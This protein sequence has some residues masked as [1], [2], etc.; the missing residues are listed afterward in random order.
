MRYVTV[1]SLVLLATVALGR[2]PG[3]GQSYLDHPAFPSDGQHVQGW[4]QP[5][6]DWVEPPPPINAPYPRVPGM[7]LGRVRQRGDPEPDRLPFPGARAIRG[8]PGLFI[9]DPRT[10]PDAFRGPGPRRGQREA[11]LFT[12]PSNVNPHQGRGS[13]SGRR[14]QR[15]RGAHGRGGAGP[16]GRVPGYTAGS[17]VFNP[18]VEQQLPEG[19]LGREGWLYVNSVLGGRGRWFPPGWFEGRRGGHGEASGGHGR[20]GRRGRGK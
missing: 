9:A 3:R 14:F 17:S 2:R 6:P 20:R 8:S 19:R 13:E 5:I 10:V 7:P 12:L 11:F 4:D 18:S 16:D 15:G 1:G